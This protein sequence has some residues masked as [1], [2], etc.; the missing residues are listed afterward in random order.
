VTLESPYK[1]GRVSGW[2]SVLGISHGLTVPMTNHTDPIHLLTTELTTL[3]ATSIGRRLLRSIEEMELDTLGATNLS[4]LA[5]A[6]EWSPKS[7]QIRHSTLA[8]L[9]PLAAGDHGVAIV[10]MNAFRQPLRDMWHSL[11]RCG[12][13]QD[14]GAQLLAALWV[15]L[16]DKKEGAD[17]ERILEVTFVQTR[18]TLRQDERRRTVLDSI[19]GMDFADC[20][21]N[22]KAPSENLLEMLTCEGVVTP[23][24]AELIRV[25][26]VDGMA[27]GDHVRRRHLDY[28][29]T[30]Q[31]RLRAERRIALYLIKNPGLR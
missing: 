19:E 6:I 16:L 7:E 4:D 14:V 11:I 21:Q 18:R 9:V 5:R 3:S 30:H 15:A 10:V 20:A 12:A 25:T 29:A 22:P 1:Q 28:K 8:G 17:V 27:F 26:R 2:R 24:E 23:D 13:N 31:R